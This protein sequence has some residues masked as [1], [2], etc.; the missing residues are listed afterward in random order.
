MRNN[1]IPEDKRHVSIFS[2]LADTNDLL[3]KDILEGEYVFDKRTP[4]DQA[5]LDRKMFNSGMSNCRISNKR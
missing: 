4:M 5:E 3:I 2:T 1:P